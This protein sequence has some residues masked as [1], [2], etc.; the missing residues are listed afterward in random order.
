MIDV[1]ALLEEMKAAPF[2]VVE[3]RAPHTGVVEQVI[4]EPGAKV[5]GGGGT[6]GERPGTVLCHLERER[7]KKPIRATLDGEVEEVFAEHA[8]AFVE[9]GT[10]LYTIRHYLTK[11][12]VIQ[13]IMK[14]A[15]FLFRAPE[16]A[17]YYFVPETD[18]KVKANGPQ[19]VRVREGQDLF[20]VSRMKRETSLPYAGPEGMIYAVY[21]KDNQS[22]E[23]GAPLI[24]V[25]PP[26]Q[27]SLIQDVVSR[28][29]SGWE[30]R[31]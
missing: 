29:K 25:C 27:V 19:S 20:I 22:V 21:F 28:V 2:K 5:S 6:W 8:G 16:Q 15:L 26:D 31:G 17:K 10:V 1:K 4:A 23:A 9:A 11:D 3:V 7:N 24:G 14:K 13:E 18:T 30:E 12:E